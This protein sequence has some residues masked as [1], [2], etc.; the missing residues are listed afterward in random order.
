LQPERTGKIKLSYSVIHMGGRAQRISLS[1]H[2]GKWQ[3][4]ALVPQSTQ[5]DVASSPTA[6]TR[7]QVNWVF[8]EM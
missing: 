6:G 8:E 1:L 3:G 4:H 7:E 2:P 5:G